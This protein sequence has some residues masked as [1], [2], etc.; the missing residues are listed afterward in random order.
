MAPTSTVLARGHRPDTAP[1]AAT[2]ADAAQRVVEYLSRRT[3]LRDWSVSRVAGG[4]QVHVH[5]HHDEFLDTGQRVP[6][7]GSFCRQMTS[8]AAHVVPDAFAD[9]D[10]AQ[11]PDAGDVRAYVGF[12]ITD[13]GAL[14]GIL[15]GV[16]SQPL[17]DGAE[18]DADLV[19][20]LS[21]LLS[22]QL[23]IARAADRAGRRAT[24]AAALAETDELTGL[25]N[26]RGWETIAADA[27]QRIDAFGDPVAV[28]VVD[29]DGLKALNDARGHA[30]GD[31]L[32]R[33]AGAALRAAGSAQD[34]V[35]RYGGDEFAILTN[36]VA[37]G[38]LPEH[39]AGFARSL[40]E[41]GV[42]ASIGH[43]FTGP[44]ERT[45]AEA[46]RLADAAMYDAKRA[47]RAGPPH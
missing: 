9:A 18:V 28:A 7:D 47:R 24:I 5:V 23:S 35:A 30:A 21:D 14:F 27:Q 3:P 16:G 20:L 8:G 32:L 1:G 15:C 19:E 45:V 38:D 34:R 29:L 13:E 11:L 26:R 10:Y 36:N 6:W 17:P 12:P 39:L 44:G 2:F 43:A 42:A 22:A 4:E 46:F 37:V 31:D 40:A 25:L 33:R 41:H